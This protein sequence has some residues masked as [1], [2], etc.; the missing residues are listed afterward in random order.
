VLGLDI[1]GTHTRGRLV[2]DDHLVAEATAPSASLPAAGRQRASDA[3]ASLLRELGLGNSLN[4]GAGLVGGQPQDEDACAGLLD[5]VC[6]GTAGTGAPAQQAFLVKL[7]A[8]LTRLGTVVVVNDARLVLAAAG[9]TDGIA[10]VAGTGS[11]AV[12]MLDGREERAGGWGYLLGDEGSGYWVVR[13]A[14]RELARREDSHAPIGGL[15]QVV[16]GLSQCPDFTSLLQS[17]YERPSPDAWAALAPA[18]MDCEDVF[19]PAVR[20]AAA[21]ALAG[22]VAE[23]H[24][25]LGARDGLAVVLAGGLLIG[26]SGLAEE[27]QRAVRSRAAVD[28][29]VA[30][31]PPV[32]GAV[33]LA[34]AAANPSGRLSTS[35]GGHRGPSS[36]N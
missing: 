14:V 28:V 16:L 20:S 23:V 30:T 33:R 1:G 31:E 25:R 18:V 26:H 12:G 21:L 9:L 10:C 35:S 24:Q 22:I 15:G 4:Q 7:L 32:S 2:R 5:A 8:P 6:V 19:A 11:I 3:L 36:G 13:E 34:L 27:T 17:W 29:M